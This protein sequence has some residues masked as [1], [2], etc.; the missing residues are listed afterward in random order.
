[1]PAGVVTAMVFMVQWNLFPRQLDHYF[2]LALGDLALRNAVQTSHSIA[3]LWPH[4][5]NLLSDSLITKL[6]DLVEPCSQ[7]LDPVLSPSF[8]LYFLNPLNAELNPIR[9]LLALV[10]A[11]HIVH[12]SRIRVNIQFNITSSA[13]NFLKWRYS[14]GTFRSRFV[15][16][17]YSKRVACSIPVRR[18]EFMFL[19]LYRTALF[20]DITQRVVVIPYQDSAC[21]GNPLP[22]LS[23]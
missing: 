22:G 12:V 7:S 3:F 15:Y 1:M 14:G 18:L 9:H 17:S 21:S 20:W 8:T 23:V 4:W 16:F 5:P 19:M 2:R 13:P 11:R 6:P 10:G